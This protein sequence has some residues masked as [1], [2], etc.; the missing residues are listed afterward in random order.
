MLPP[1][2]PLCCQYHFPA[3]FTGGGTSHWIVHTST[4]LPTVAWDAYS[5]ACIGP[6]PYLDVYNNT[7]VQLG[8][9]PIEP[10]QTRYK[11]P[12]KQFSSRVGRFEKRQEHCIS[13]RRFS[14]SRERNQQFGEVHV[15][16]Q[17]QQWACITDEESL[18]A[19]SSLQ[20]AN[21]ML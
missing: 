2:L 6:T 19:F 3:D 11:Q 17:C 9:W 15:A 4:G 21:G 12:C 18:S 14:W 1:T 7:E 10:A 8:R 5:S 20:G 13:T 16:L